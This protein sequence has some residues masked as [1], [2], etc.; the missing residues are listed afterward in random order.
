MKTVNRNGK[1]KHGK[2]ADL[3]QCFQR[4]KCIRRPG[5]WIGGLMMHEVEDAKYVRVMHEP[6]CPVKISVVDEEHQG[7]RGKEIKPAILP[8]P[9]IMRGVRFNGGIFNQEQRHEGK[10]QHGNDGIADL[11]EVLPGGGKPRLDLFRLQCF[12]EN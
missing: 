11:A 2:D 8:D 9:G 1:Q 12:P 10:E 4:V 6:V 7:E 5:R 3:H